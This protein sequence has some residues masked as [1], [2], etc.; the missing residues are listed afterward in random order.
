MTDFTRIL[1]LVRSRFLGFG[2]AVIHP[3]SSQSEPETINTSVRHLP[4]L[5]DMAI[6][7]QCIIN[8]TTRCVPLGTFRSFQTIAKKHHIPFPVN[9]VFLKPTTPR[10][11]IPVVDVRL[12]TAL[13]P[14]P[15]IGIEGVLPIFRGQT[16][17]D[18]RPNKALRPHLYKQHL[19]EYPDLTLLCNIAEHGVVPHW[20]NPSERV[21][22]RPVPQNYPSADMGSAV[23]T[24]KLVT[25]YHRSRCILA[26]RS[27]LVEEPCYYSS[28]F[29]LV[30]KKDIPLSNDGRIIHDLSAPHGSSINDATNTDWTPDDRWD[31]YS[32]IARRVLQLRRQYPD[33]IIYVL[34]A[35]IA[36]AFLHVPVHARHASAFG[37]S[38]PRS[39]VGIMSGTAVFGWT[40]SP[41]CF[42]VFGKAARHYHRYGYSYV[43][44]LPEPFW[45]F[46]WVDDIV[47]I[48]VDIGDRLHCAEQRLRN[49]IKLV[50]GPDGWHEGKFTTW[51]RQIHAVAIDWNLVD[52]SVSIPQ[53]KIHKMKSKVTEALDLQY[54]TKKNL[55]SLV[56]VLRHVTTFIPIAKPFMQRL[57]RAMER[58]GNPGTP[59]ND[60]LHGDLEWWKQLVFE[61]EFAG[62]P[63]SMF[64]STPP[65]SDGWVVIHNESSFIV[66]GLTPRRTFRTTRFQSD[67]G[68]T[69]S[70]CLFS[71][72]SSWIPVNPSHTFESPGAGASPSLQKAD[73]ISYQSPR[74][75][76]RNSSMRCTHPDLPICS[77]AYADRLGRITAATGQLKRVAINE[78]FLRTYT[79]KFNH[80]VNFCEE[81]GFPIWIDELPHERQA[82]IVSLFAGRC[83]L[84][85]HNKSE[86]R[87]QIL[88]IRQ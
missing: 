13:I 75:E 70:Q 77:Y 69:L 16:S 44:G 82:R 78:S 23:V 31:P 72:V 5:F 40:A 87:E 8:G 64:D 29:V 45:I 88:G 60:M 85:G 25:E 12:I 10:L 52:L 9:R 38:I 68:A 54:I 11:N 15:H 76:I 55:S 71:V 20:R 39:H 26:D 3:L 21:G 28:A 58:F 56:G 34:G 18:Q 36:E 41:G 51:S 32:S 4:S 66:E 7:R 62:V 27:A 81:F 79:K 33:A 59:M 19:A 67:N 42:A 17:Q 50:F 30:P 53:R 74:A 63:M 73:A 6:S 57:I 24:D 47:V 48:E 86:T 22:V 1:H 43:L 2:T 35:D 14:V 37:G 84:E 49:A 61:N 80:W 46:Q 83:A 65:E